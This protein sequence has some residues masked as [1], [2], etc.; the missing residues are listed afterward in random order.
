M[1]RNSSPRS[2]FELVI[3][4][5]LGLSQGFIGFCATHFLGRI[6]VAQKPLNPRRKVGGEKITASSG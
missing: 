3:F 2:R 4:S 6:R 1:T 5:P